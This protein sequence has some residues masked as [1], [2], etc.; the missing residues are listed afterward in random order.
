MGRYIVCNE[1]ELLR[2]EAEKAKRAL[3]QLANEA[4]AVLHW[5]PEIE[6]AI[7]RTNLS[8]F[9]LRISEA[10]AALTHEPAFQAAEEKK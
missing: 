4:Q 2:A 6:R 5:E 9:K 10:E 3:F 7:G 8:V 1:C